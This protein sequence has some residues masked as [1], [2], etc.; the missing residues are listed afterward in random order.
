M[1][2]QIK[3]PEDYKKGFNLGY[4]MARELDLKSPI[5]KSGAPIANSLISY[6]DGILQYLRENNLLKTLGKS[7]SI[8]TFTERQNSNKNDKGK[9]L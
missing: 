1:D 5:F 6:Q 3:I 9:S 7:T 2:E 4:N 8:S